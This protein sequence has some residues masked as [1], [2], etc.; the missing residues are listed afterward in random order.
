MSGAPPRART[1]I[2]AVL[3]HIPHGRCPAVVAA[4]PFADPLPGGV[5]AG[6]RLDLAAV[7]AGGRQ[8]ACRRTACTW[9]RPRSAVQRH[10]GPAAARAG[11]RGQR[12]PT[13]GRSARRPAARP[14]AARPRRSAPGSAASAA[15]RL[16]TAPAWWRHRRPPRPRSPAAA[17]TVSAA[18]T[19][20]TTASRRQAGT[21]AAGRAAELR[22]RP[23]SRPP[24]AAA[25]RDRGPGPGG[26]S[27]PA[28]GRLR[29]AA[30]AMRP[31][32]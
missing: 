24:R 26:A 28:A 14:P 4:A 31:A 30:A 12:P 11:R 29:R 8:P 20:P 22:A 21:A 7:R 3:P 2:E 17:A 23:G 10:P 18:A 5:A 25:G 1:A 19:R 6:D 27:R 32:R 16:R 9:P 13:R 15:A